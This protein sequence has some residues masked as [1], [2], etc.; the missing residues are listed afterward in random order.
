MAPPTPRKTSAP[1]FARELYGFA[2][3]LADTPYNELAKAF[4]DAGWLSRLVE[5]GTTACYDGT[6]L[7]HFDLLVGREIDMLEKVDSFTM[8]MPIGAGPVSVAARMAARETVIYLLSSRLPPMQQPA[9][10]PVVVPTAVVD[11]EPLPGEVPP[12]PV[13]AETEVE[14]TVRVVER[15]EADGLP[16]FRDLYEIGADE[17]RTTGDIITAVL[18]EVQSFLAATESP[19]AVNALATKNPEMMQFVRDVGTEEDIDDL[20]AM[21]AK[22]RNE[23]ARPAG[24][25][26]R[27]VP[28]VPRPN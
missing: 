18:D 1:A 27:R 26:R 14:P 24:A 22:R 5:T 23:L 9:A 25:P 17:V 8:R 7:V 21:V 2:A 4:F 3:S 11:D 20:K 15:R 12:A 16:I 28:A 10:A 19:E 13:A 6:V